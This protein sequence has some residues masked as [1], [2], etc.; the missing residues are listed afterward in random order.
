MQQ[1]KRQK[2]GAS[3]DAATDAPPPQ[4][5]LGSKVSATTDAVHY[6]SQHW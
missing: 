6:G 2:T 1:L 5:T 4:Q 3:T